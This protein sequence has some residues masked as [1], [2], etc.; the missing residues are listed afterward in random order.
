[1]R[2][3]ACAAALLLVG[4]CISSSPAHPSPENGAPFLLI[5]V[6]LAREA[7]ASR[8]S[9][10]GLDVAGVNRRALTAQVVVSPEELS[11]L[12]GLGFTYTVK[13]TGRPL[14]ERAEALG[15]YTDPAELEA[16]IDQT[17]AAHPDLVQKVILK[18]ALFEGQKLLAVK[19][20]ADVSQDH[21][22]PV[23]LLDAQHHAREV[24]TPEIAKDA[25]GVLASEYGTDPRVTAWLDAIEIW[26]V[27]SVNPDGA[28]YVFTVNNLWRKNRDPACAVDLNRN[29]GWNWNSCG[30]SS[31]EC[32]NETYHGSGPESE[33]ETQAMAALVDRIR[34]MFSLSYHSYGEYLLYPYGCED[35]GEMAVYDDLARGLGGLLEDDTGATGRYT[36]GPGWSAIYTTDGTSDDTFYGRYGAFSFVIEVNCCAFQPD[37]GRWRDITVQR[38]RTAWQYFLD[39]TLAYPSIQGRVTDASTGQ[40]L[41]ATVS[42]QEVALNRGEVP[43]RASGVGR[44]GWPVQGNQTYHATFSQPGYASQIREVAVGA[45][46]ALVEAAL[47][48]AS[49]ATVPHDPSPSSGTLSQ[50]TGTLLAWAS[51]GATSFE[52]H[53]GTSESPPL[54]ASVAEPRFAPQGLELGKTYFWQIVAVGPWGKSPGP[55]WSFSTR[56][57]AITSVKKAG[58]PF[59]L[60]VDGQGFAANQTLLVDGAPAPLTLVKSATRLVAKGAGFKPLVPGGET[61]SLVVR[62]LAGGESA[63]YA[64]RW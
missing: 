23:F 5:E 1:M 47:A 12:A 22:R 11:R 28:M 31:E 57:C 46:P 33:P 15:E 36:T 35:P 50:D 10:A 20:T 45:G 56:P 55:M 62:D 64:F 54:M 53:L 44:F 4:L 43:R 37:Y 29:Y 17:V 32:S 19:I 51:E 26:V 9:A 21:D 25:I 40:P 39:E 7:D 2:L 18:D 30:G 38:Q 61:V 8:L 3:K 16:F 27:A 60:V 63:P 24:M 41:A 13:D 42:L 52:V 59:R 6:P 14:R 58:N 34:P 48:P 49:P